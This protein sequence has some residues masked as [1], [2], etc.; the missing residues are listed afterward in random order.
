MRREWVFGI[1][2]RH[3]HGCRPPRRRGIYIRNQYLLAD[4]VK[5]LPG[6]ETFQKRFTRV[7]LP[8]ELL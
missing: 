7:V 6:I 4:A 3:D 8:R 5:R 1:E 2:A